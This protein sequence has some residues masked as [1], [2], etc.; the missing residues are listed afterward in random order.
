L[1]H[2]PRIWLDVGNAEGRRTLADADL[3]ER[4]LK[5]NGWRSDVDLHYER[6]PGGTHDEG[7][8]AERVDP[9]LRFL[10][11]SDSMIPADREHSF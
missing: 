5:A 1:D 11:P 7:A 6:V 3:L 9:L 8:W 2:R 4:R 10:F